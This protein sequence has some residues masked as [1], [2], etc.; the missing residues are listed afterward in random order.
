MGG[1][2]SRLRPAKTEEDADRQEIVDPLQEID[3]YPD[4][5]EPVDDWYPDLPADPPPPPQPA[6]HPP[7]R[8]QLPPWRRNLMMFVPQEDLLMTTPSPR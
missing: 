6:D 2:S 7:P 4:E 1:E 3:W 5:M 8:D